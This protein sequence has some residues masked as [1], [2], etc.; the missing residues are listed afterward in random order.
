MSSKFPLQ[1]ELEG[2]FSSRLN[3]EKSVLLAEGNGP[4]PDLA[5]AERLVLDPLHLDFAIQPTVV[6]LWPVSASQLARVSP[7][8]A[9]FLYG[10]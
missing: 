5:S 1:G 6:P 7:Q 2:L 4:P 9:F 3:Y 10:T 8:F